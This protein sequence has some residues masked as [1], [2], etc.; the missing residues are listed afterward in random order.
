MSTCGPHC[1]GC[2]S[3]PLPDGGYSSSSGY[4]DRS[5]WGRSPTLSRTEKDARLKSIEEDREKELRESKHPVT[6]V[7]LATA[8]VA[9]STILGGP[10]GG[11]VMGTILGAGALLFA[12]DEEKK[13][14]AKYDE[15]AKEYK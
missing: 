12:G 7:G 11:L 1:N 5:H 6:T 2:S 8:F 4:G 9:V 13:I 3:C 14:N 15:K 10:V